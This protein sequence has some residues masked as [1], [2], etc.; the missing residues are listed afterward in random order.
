[1]GDDPTG[2]QAISGVFSNANTQVNL[3]G[4]ANIP[5]TNDTILSDSA[6]GMG[7][8]F[9]MTKGTGPRRLTW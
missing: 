6:A 2:L 8:H 3:T 9:W 4:G 1:M 7:E 5:V